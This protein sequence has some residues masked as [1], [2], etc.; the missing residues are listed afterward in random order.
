MKDEVVHTMHPEAGRKNKNISRRKY[1]IIKEAITE[2]L[3][4]QELTHT[5]LVKGLEKNLGK[6]FPENI[7][8]CTMTVKLDLEARGV[9]E[10]TSSKPPKYRLRQHV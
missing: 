10:R 2:A 6:T 4:N 5:E 3:R 8:W 9:I 1:E 7:S